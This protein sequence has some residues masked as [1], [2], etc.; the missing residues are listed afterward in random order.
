MPDADCMLKLRQQIH[1]IKLHTRLLRKGKASESTI[2]LG[3]CHTAEDLWSK[4]AEAFGVDEDNIN[5][6]RAATLSE[7]YAE[8]NTR[9]FVITKDD[10]DADQKLKYLVRTLEQYLV[11]QTFA[12]VELLCELVMKTT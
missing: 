3:R 9:F 8:A 12:E 11:R 10:P 2:S 6:F 7:M 5:F 1:S 4:Y